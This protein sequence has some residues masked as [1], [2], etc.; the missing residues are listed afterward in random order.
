MMIDS[1]SDSDAE[2][3]KRA[4]ADVAGSAYRESITSVDGFTRGPNGRVKFNKDTK[5]RRR[6]NNEAED[7]EMRD[8]E[9]GPSNKNKRKSEVR[10]GHEFKAKVTCFAMLVGLL[11]TDSLRLITESRR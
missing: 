10:L 3:A 11:V 2:D 7:V 5:K 4:S 8:A 6:E 1:D 9:A